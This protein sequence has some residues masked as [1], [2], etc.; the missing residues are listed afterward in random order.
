MVKLMIL[1]ILFVLSL[2][3][4]LVGFAEGPAW[5]GFTS[6]GSTVGCGGTMWWM[7]R[8]EEG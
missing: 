5:L 3:G 1:A 8:R 4:M 6:A 2:C 7:L